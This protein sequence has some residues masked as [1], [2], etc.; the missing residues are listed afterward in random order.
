[1]AIAK[2]TGGRIG[3]VVA[4]GAVAVAL[5]V[6]VALVLRPGPSVDRARLA[7]DRGDWQ[8]ATDDVAS[9][10][11]R[12]PANEE[13]TRLRARSLARLGRV[14][15]SL[16]LD[17]KLGGGRLQAED[18]F[19][20]GRDFLAAGKPVLGWAALDAASKLDP[21]HPGVAEALARRSKAGAKG[22]RLSAI[23]DGRALAELVVGLANLAGDPARTLDGLLRRD[24]ST[25]LKLATPADARKLL[26]RALLED[27][28]SGE[29]LGRLDGLDDPEAHWLK[30]RAR[31]VEGNVAGSKAELGQAGAFGEDDPASLEPARYVGARQCE[32]CHSEI[33]ESQQAS[34]H[35][36]TIAW[37]AGL[38]TVPL[39]K[40]DLTDPIDPAIV[41]RFRRENDRI[42]LA[43]GPVEKAARAVIDY[44]LGS[45]HHGVTMLAKG[46]DGRHRSLRVSYYTGGDHWGLTSGFEAKPADPMGYLGEA[47]SEEGFNACLNCHTTRFT[48]EKDRSG[49]EAVDRGIG[50]ERCHG[51]GDH[52]V[53]AVEAN[54]PSPAIARPRLATPARR[55]KLCAQCHASDGVIP[56]ADP[57][58]IRFQATTLPFSRCVSESGGRLDCVACH[59]PHTNVETSPAY[60]EARCLACHGQGQGR[61]AKAAS[62]MRV[63]AVAATPCPTNPAGGCLPCHMPKV[64]GIMPFMAF[65]DHHIRVRRADDGR[66]SGEKGAGR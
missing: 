57:R 52:H 55:L 24:R 14:D 17:A 6:G 10:L 16:A 3:K 35:A 32:S 30:A 25:F 21:R 5:A 42:D 15:E 26:A 45:G 59:D 40:G 49:P 41:H 18:L 36:G 13:A 44:A 62:G 29:A 65:T 60:Y 23:A 7:Y 56:P 8:K 20:V 37:G 43:S 34:H 54:W 2:T 38:A 61:G 39:P 33:Y 64:S 66:P 46:E 22:D 4:F 58:F 63:E 53:R 28:R 31:L 11:A 47:L 27:G 19:L 50:C 12:E 48:S 51:P 9:V 1:M